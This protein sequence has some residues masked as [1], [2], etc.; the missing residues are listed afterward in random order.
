MAMGNPAFSN[1]IFAGYDQVYGATRGAVT[2]TVQG[3]IG[4]SF[5]LLAILSA[6]AIWAWT[7][8]AQGELQRDRPAGL[9][10]RRGWSWRSSRSSSRPSRPGPPRSTRPSRGWP[11]ARSR[12][13]IE[14]SVGVRGAYP[15]IAMQAVSLT[16][17]TLFC[18]LFVYATGIDP[19]SPT[20]SARGRRGDRGDLPGVPRLDA[21]WACS[22][23][24]CRSSARRPRWASASAW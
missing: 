17:G 18:M 6:T 8:T 1:D 9:G 2:M 3:T 14:H 19:R 16:C 5:A 7:A 21:C 12:S 22:A 20:S 23:V 15:G 4:K 10:D 11:S 13:L 24:R